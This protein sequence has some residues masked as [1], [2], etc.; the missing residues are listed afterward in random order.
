V[1]IGPEFFVLTSITPTVPDV[2]RPFGFVANSEY[3]LG[4]F[5]PVTWQRILQWSVYTFLAR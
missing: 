1:D 4:V 2:H 3:K 5:L